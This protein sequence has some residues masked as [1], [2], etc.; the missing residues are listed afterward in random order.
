MRTQQQGS[1]EEQTA[2]GS[3]GTA[4]WMLLNPPHAFWLEFKPY[5]RGAKGL[6]KQGRMPGP[7]HISSFYKKDKGFLGFRGTV[8]NLGT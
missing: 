6:M 7:Q 4:C 8:W 2:G 1:Q 5:C 3:Q